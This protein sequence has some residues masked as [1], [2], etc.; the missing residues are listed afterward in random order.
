MVAAFLTTMV[1]ID[2]SSMLDFWR[3]ANSG[4]RTSAAPIAPLQLHMLFLLVLVRMFLM[5]FGC[6]CFGFVLLF[7]L[8]LAGLTRSSKAELADQG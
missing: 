3:L 1:T 5:C 6:L 4:R 2:L 7:G 8:E